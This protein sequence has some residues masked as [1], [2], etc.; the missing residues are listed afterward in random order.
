MAEQREVIYTLRVVHSD[1]NDRVLRQFGQRQQKT[2]QQIDRD[3][4][5]AARE[6]EKRQNRVFQNRVK[7]LDRIAKDERRT[8]EQAA[9]EAERAAREEE[10]RQQ[11][12]FQNRVKLL[13]RIRREEEKR[14]REAERTLSD[15]TN[16]IESANAALAQGFNDTAEGVLRLGRGMTA[17]GLVGE[18]ETQKILDTLLKVQASFDLVLGGIKAYQ[19][20]ITLVKNYRAAVLAAAAAEQVL[21]AARAK[22]AAAGGA[23][24][25]GSA[26]SGLAG[27]AAPAAIGAGGTIGAFLAA[28]S[29]TVLALKVFSETLT[30]SATQIGS[31]SNTIAEKEVGIAAYLAEK[32][33]T[34][35]AR[36]ASGIIAG[37]PGASILGD[38]LGQG[39]DVADSNARVRSADSRREA[40]LAAQ[41]SEAERSAIGQARSDFAAE[42]EVEAAKRK[43]DAEKEA[44]AVKLSA[45]RE[46]LRLSEQE[47]DRVQ[48][49]KEASEQRLLGAKRS[50]GLLDDKEQ[51]RLFAIQRR[52]AAGEDLGVA[53]LR[54]LSRVG[55]ADATSTVNRA[56]ERR[57]DDAVR[58]LGGDSFEGTF[59]RADRAEIDALAGR[60]RTL[61]VDVKTQRN[62]ELQVQA[63]SE[64]IA[65]EL[66]DIAAEEL[67]KQDERIRR[68]FEQAME[69]RMRELS[70]M[71]NAE[72]AARQ[73]SLGGFGR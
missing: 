2:Q 18:E 17:L 64:R 72:R 36:A 30:G 41:F 32:V 20:I 55:T 10:K 11:R 43:L 29:G 49:M 40:M 7:L 56:A 9:R 13:D 27:A 59:G 54:E 26:A 21:A 37:V 35:R 58:R 63:D 65:Q 42:R 51:A 1:E 34:D 61:S 19:G 69:R 70:N 73:R 48:K 67:A 53:D 24:A 57:A 47:L 62:I 66:A 71:T 6:E 50:F 15:S 52:A 3:A 44:A 5:R 31:L 33:G 12:V 68:D 39:A 16:R 23:S 4:E 60:E 46:S 14:Q 38:I 25:A 8:R 28:I 22:T 45:S